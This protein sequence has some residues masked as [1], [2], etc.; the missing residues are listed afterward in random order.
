MVP[1]RE[2]TQRELRN[3]SGAIMRGLDAGESFLVTRN[4]IA[5]GELVP[6]RRSRFVRT[7]LLLDIVRGGPRIDYD[8]FRADVDAFVDQDLTPRA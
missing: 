2:I 6:I 4:G 5:V 7:D 3:D 8:R 1:M